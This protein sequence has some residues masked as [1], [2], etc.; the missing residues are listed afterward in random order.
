MAD[1]KRA[2]T[3]VTRLPVLDQQL[4]QSYEAASSPRERETWEAALTLYDLLRGT[5]AGPA[6]LDEALRVLR[7]VCRPNGA[8]DD[9][10]VLARAEAIRAAR[11]KE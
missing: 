11:A 3:S 6:V 9:D 2:I 4:K 10:W 1:D 7:G 5:D 8:V